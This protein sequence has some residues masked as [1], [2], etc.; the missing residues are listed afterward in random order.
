MAEERD[1]M[2]ARQGKGRMPASF[3]HPVNVTIFGNS[4]RF[5]KNQLFL[6]ETC[7]FFTCI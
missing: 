3:D 2:G 5:S 7:V 1:R 6:I 4:L